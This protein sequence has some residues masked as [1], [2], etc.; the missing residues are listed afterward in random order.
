MKVIFILIILL[1][2][3][4]VLSAQD[5]SPS[6]TKDPP[7]EIPKS[8]ADFQSGRSEPS[9]R[10]PPPVSINIRQNVI[11]ANIK[12]EAYIHFLIIIERHPNNRSFT[13]AWDCYDSGGSTLK[14]LEGDKAPRMF[15]SYNL[16]KDFYLTQGPCTI[17][18]NLHRND[19]KDIFIKKD[20]KVVGPNFEGF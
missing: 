2:N 11:M 19:G 9:P 14:S 3:L 12:G 7:T 20:I 13:L 10:P 5:K 18:V 6:K 4:N 1:F 8:A 15:D 16:V 17:S